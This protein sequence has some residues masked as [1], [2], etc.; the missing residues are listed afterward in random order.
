M[1]AWD[2]RAMRGARTVSS[3]NCLKMGISPLCLRLEGEKWEGK[4]HEINL[5]V[6]SHLKRC[7]DEMSWKEI[8]DFRLKNYQSPLYG[9]GY[10]ELWRRY[11]CNQL[12]ILSDCALFFLLLFR[13]WLVNCPDW[14]R[15]F[16]FECLIKR[17]APFTMRQWRLHCVH[18]KALHVSAK[19]RERMGQREKPYRLLFAETWTN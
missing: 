19:P 14:N 5:S 3:L 8:L 12:R 18:L 2:M 11:Q 1:H 9:S 17:C 16:N 7:R 6:K 10:V 13:L 15:K 4:I